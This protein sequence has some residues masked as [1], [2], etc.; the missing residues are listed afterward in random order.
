MQR[1]ASYRIS[2]RWPFKYY[3][4]L[5]KQHSRYNACDCTRWHKKTE[6]IRP[7]FSIHQRAILDFNHDVSE[8]ARGFLFVCL[9]GYS[10]AK[11]S[12]YLIS[13][14]YDQKKKN[15]GLIKM[16]LCRRKIMQIPSHLFHI[17][18]CEPQLTGEFYYS[19]E[20]KHL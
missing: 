9:C 1:K 19:K 4:V 8:F 7:S 10:P 15:R 3:I 16:W 18:F 20:K 11:F 2:I 6:A 13:Y 17:S 14:T 5:S 12:V